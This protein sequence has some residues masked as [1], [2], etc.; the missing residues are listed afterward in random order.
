MA[1]SMKRIVF[2]T[3]AMVL[4][5][6]GQAF[7]VG[8][9]TA[10]STR[11]GYLQGSFNKPVGLVREFTADA[12]AATIPD[13]TID[14]LSGHLV[15]IDVEFDGTTAPN[16]LVV[17]VKSA[18]GT[19]LLTSASLTASGRVTVTSP[20]PFADGLLVSFS[21]NTTN[22]AKAKVVFYVY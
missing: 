9:W 10:Y 20:I 21:T 11:E 8:S 15:A 7:A 2:L 16:A 4:L 12:S 1:G 19:T 18:T 17:T 22:S 13:L 5:T 14:D 6:T 3:M